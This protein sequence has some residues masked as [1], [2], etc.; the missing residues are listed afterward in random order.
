MGLRGN[1]GDGAERQAEVLGEAGQI[2]A[3]AASNECERGD[4][5]VSGR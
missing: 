5:G 4:R 1:R 3:G 2:S